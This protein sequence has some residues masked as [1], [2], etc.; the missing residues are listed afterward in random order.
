[1]EGTV[2]SFLGVTGSTHSHVQERL[3][4]KYNF[5]Q[6]EITDAI[7][8][9]S[10]D[11]EFNKIEFMAETDTDGANAKLIYKSNQYGRY[12]GNPKKREM[13]H[14]SA[15]SGDALFAV[16]KIA[17]ISDPRLWKLSAAMPR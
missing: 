7:R 6:K 16:I 12:W 14:F 15:S 1:M 10:V 11:A 17:V 9:P 3:G 5:T 2:N 13:K 8:S 4:G